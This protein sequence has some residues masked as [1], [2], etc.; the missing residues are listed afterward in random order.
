MATGERKCSAAAL[1]PAAAAWMPPWSSGW[2]NEVTPPTPRLLQ[3]Q[4]VTSKQIL[5][6]IFPSA[7]SHQP[8]L[9]PASPHHILSYS[10]LSDVLLHDPKAHTYFQGSIPLPDRCLGCDVSREGPAH[11]PVWEVCCVLALGLFFHFCTPFG[12]CPH[13]CHFL[14]SDSGLPTG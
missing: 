6:V 2:E 9:L 5:I 11:S 8:V 1:L 10:S 12:K 3:A 14:T 4:W 13:I 7:H